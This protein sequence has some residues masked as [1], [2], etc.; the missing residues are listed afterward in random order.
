MTFTQDLH[1]TLCI[2]KIGW[3]CAV[4]LNYFFRKGKGTRILLMCRW[5]RENRIVLDDQE[6]AKRV[7]KIRMYKRDLMNAEGD[8]MEPQSE[9][10]VVMWRLRGSCFA[11]L[12]CCGV[13]LRLPPQLRAFSLYGK[14]QTEPWFPPAAQNGI[15]PKNERGNGTIPRRSLRLFCIAISKSFSE[16]YRV[17]CMSLSGHLVPVSYSSGHCAREPH[18]SCQWYRVWHVYSFHGLLI[19]NHGMCSRSK[20]ED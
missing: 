13:S 5:I 7:K 17:C 11:R 1:C 15:V 6:P 2:R 18:S 8:D 14:W 9:Y 19:W 12:T 16:A 10:G 4:V 20:D 3:C